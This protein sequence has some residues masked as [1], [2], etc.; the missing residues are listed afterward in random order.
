MDGHAGGYQF[1]R[2]CRDHTLIAVPCGEGVAAFGD[3][4]DSED[5]GFQGFASGNGLNVALGF[6]LR[7][8]L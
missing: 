2:G 6:G 4:K 3:G 1:H 8:G 7:E 5:G